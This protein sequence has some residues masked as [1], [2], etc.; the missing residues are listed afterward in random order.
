MSAAR[1][2]LRTRLANFQFFNWMALVKAKGYREIVLDPRH[3]KT[4]KWDKDEVR[5]R[6]DSI[7]VPGSLLGR[8][9]VSFGNHGD[10]L[11]D[12]MHHVER[13]AEHIRGGGGFER[14]TT[15]RSPEK[16]RYTVT[17]RR[18]DRHLTR[19][20]NETAWRTFAAAIGARVIEDWT[21]E[22]IQL[23]QRVALYAGAEM[24]FFV[25][26]GP[27]HLCSLTPYPMMVFGCPAAEGSLLRIGVKP[28]EQLPWAL[29]HQRLVW[30][31]DDLDVIEREFER[32][33]AERT[34]PEA[35]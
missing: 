12:N 4:D 6:F 7:I 22:R 32:W 24:N 16:V 11:G 33:R 17:L 1:Y 9:K 18:L 8:M 31:P 20:S 19:N 13:F 10:E 34:I 21:V 28:G 2:D 23:L 15:V 30:A 26:N 35:A 3:P 5:R 25:C 14:F 29:P 27:M